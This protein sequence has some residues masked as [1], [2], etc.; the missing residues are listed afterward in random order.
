MLTRP[1]PCQAQSPWGGGLPLETSQAIS[2][3]TFIFTDG[4]DPE[5]QLQGGEC[6]PQPN[7]AAVSEGSWSSA[8]QPPA[9]YTGPEELR[10]LLRVIQLIENRAWHPGSTLPA[11]LWSLADFP[12]PLAGATSPEEGPAGNHA[13]QAC[14][15]GDGPASQSCFPV[16]LLSWDC[17]WLSSAWTSD[18]GNRVN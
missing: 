5:L 15:D 13:F 9:V 2:L 3:Q 14:P 10:H 16:G 12:G 17:K 11:M 4:D 8:M 18:G 1:R 6:P 7:L